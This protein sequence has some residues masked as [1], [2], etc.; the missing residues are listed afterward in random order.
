[1]HNWIEFDT[2]RTLKEFE[3]GNWIQVSPRPTFLLFGLFILLKYY[4][5]NNTHT[6]T[7]SNTVEPATEFLISGNNRK[8]GV[9]SHSSRPK[10]WLSI[11]M[12]T[13]LNSNY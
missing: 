6:H 8:L 9:S 10:S 7:Y 5:L 12:S 2:P 3:P 11:S 13:R 1:M 4:T